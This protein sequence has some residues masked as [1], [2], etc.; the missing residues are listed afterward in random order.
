MEDLDCW[1]QLGLVSPPS[2]SC[3]SENSAGLR[4]SATKPVGGAEQ[5][6]MEPTD[7]FPVRGFKIQ[8]PI[9]DFGGR[10]VELVKLG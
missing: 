10:G 1:P 9:A 5:D 3:H 6:T 7:A 2:H 4:S 8:E